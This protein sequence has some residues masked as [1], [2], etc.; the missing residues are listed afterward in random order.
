MGA[1]L[2]QK[3]HMYRCWT[4][5][6][7]G[8]WHPH[9]HSPCAH[10]EYVGLL[11]RTLGPV[12]LASLKGLSSFGKAMRELRRV[13]VGRCGL[14]EPWPV[15]RVVESYVVP[16]LR[17]RYE[18]AA[19]SLSRDGLCD[20]RDTKIS[21]FVKSEKLAKEKVSKP[22][23]IMGRSPRYNLE[24]ACYLKPVEHAVY[25]AF[26]GWGARFLTHTRLIGKGLAGKERAD[27]IR[28][29]MLSR[30]GVV[31]VELDC[32]SF[33]SHLCR[34]MLRSE[35]GVYTGLCPD[36]R[37]ARL[38][39]WQLRCKGKGAAGVRFSVSG[40]RASGD[41]N[42]GLGNTLLMC[43]LVLGA[44]RSLRLKFDFLADGDNA[45]L[46]V[47][48]EDAATWALRL[49]G[50]FL[51]YG[52]EVTIGEFVGT[53]ETVVFGQSKPCRVVDGWTMVRDPWKTMS[54][55]FSGHQHYA[56]MRGGARVLRAVSYCEAVLNR[57]VP[58]LQ[59]FAHA[60]LRA[61]RGVSFPKEPD[62][63][64]YEYR[65]VVSRDNR[66]E[67]RNWTPVS[68][69]TRIS[70]F[71]SWGVSV[72]EQIRIET[73]LDSLVVNLPSTWVGVPVSWAWMEDLDWLEDDGLGEV[74]RRGFR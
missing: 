54:H 53:V 12:P 63:E 22:R 50:L 44:A 71:L 46:F 40:V 51:E 2:T 33:E 61:T 19:V 24:L 62:L 74:Q 16:R 11:K 43:G 55:A 42:T 5:P 73:L 9:L 38:L 28:R 45:V 66:W 48:S 35:H 59:A 29:K 30:P 41:F 37:L 67:Q 23:I 60:M 1:C 68:A 64:N 65:R 32:K 7:Q 57:G 14:V 15:N 34:T 4:P 26:R 13:L 39:S 72:E 10:N 3:R 31:A 70:F 25:P 6:L 8:V 52:H 27:L 58:V 18:E 47:M 69:V 17:K 20:R 49:P 36:P 21:A 56:E